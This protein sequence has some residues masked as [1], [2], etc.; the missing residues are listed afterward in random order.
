L[1]TIGASGA[2]LDSATAGQT[3]AIGYRY[4]YSTTLTSSSGGNLE[5]TG[6]GHGDLNY[7]LPGSGGLIKS[8]AG[9]WTLSGT[10]TYT[11]ATTLDS[12]MLVVSTRIGNTAVSVNNSATLAGNGSI[13]GAVTVV[14]GGRL[15]P[16]VSGIGRLTMSNNLTMQSG[17]T[18]SIELNKTSA[19]NDSLL[20][21]GTANYGGTLSVTNTSGTLAAGDRF[22][23]FTATSFTGD[24]ASVAGSPGANRG[25][26]FLPA[27]GEL[28][29]SSITPV[30]Q[31]ATLS[32]NTLIVS[33]PADHIGWTL[34]AQTNSLGTNWTV[35]ASSE[36]TNMMQF[37]IAPEI[38][39]MFF[40]LTYP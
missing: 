23:L 18:V 38:P 9:T 6:V 17:G 1:F 26:K 7:G 3:F 11:G 24:F 39:A 35:I 32:N 4:D 33:W 36:T 10:N 16:G 37:F 13:G 31:T 2:T 30:N 25:W 22:K 12:G 29:V 40:K 5:L 20:I 15:S 28:L 21:T 8:G 14:A 34:L 19:M 27:S